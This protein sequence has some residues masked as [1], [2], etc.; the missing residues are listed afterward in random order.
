MTVRFPSGVLLLN[1]CLTVRAHAANSHQGKGWEQVTDST[2]KW[3]SDNCDGVIFLLWG[4]YAQKKA[5]IVDKVRLSNYCRHLFN[6]TLIISFIWHTEETSLTECATSFAT[7][8]SPRISWLQAF[9]QVQC[10]AW[11]TRQAGYRLEWLACRVEPPH[12]SGAIAFFIETKI[13]ILKYCNW[14]GYPITTPVE[15]RRCLVKRERETESD[16]VFDKYETKI[17]LWNV[18]NI[19]SYNELYVSSFV[20]WTF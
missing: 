9:F 12:S 4:S 15:L 13:F 14:I 20:W 5:A 6:L 18:I 8:S 16:H 19:V 7:I 2:I 1:A 11:E 10:L 3:I 17:N